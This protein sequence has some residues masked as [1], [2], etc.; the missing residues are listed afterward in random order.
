MTTNCDASVDFNAGCGVAFNDPEPTCSSYGTS[1]NQNGGGWYVM[2]RGTDSVKIWFF[3]REK[4]EDVPEVICQGAPRGEPMFPD[5]SW[6]E[7][8]ANFPFYPQYCDYDQH[9]N[10]HMMVFDLTFCVSCPVSSSGSVQLADMYLSFFKGDWAGNVWSTSGCG[11]GTCSDC[12]TI[13]FSRCRCSNSLILHLP[14]LS[15]T[16]QV[17]SL[18][19]TG[20]SIA[21]GFT[22]PTGSI[23]RVSIPSCTT[24]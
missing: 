3:P 22:R 18:R 2:Y 6:G 21:C 20:K 24:S 23:E 7:P 10:A 16:T 15:T 9:F 14:Q 1:F 13:K 17:H 12:K 8:D 11:T 5:A 19:L 4:I